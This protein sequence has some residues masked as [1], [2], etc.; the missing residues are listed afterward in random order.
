MGILIKNGEI[1]TASDRFKGDVYCSDGKIMAVGPNL[2]KGSSQ[3]EVIDA[4]GNVGS[5]A[6]QAHVPH[7][8]DLGP[9]AVDDGPAYS[10]VGCAPSAPEEVVGK[11][12]AEAA[13]VTVAK[14]AETP[15]EFGLGQNSKS[16]CACTIWSGA[17]V[18]SNTRI[19]D[20]NFR[21]KSVQ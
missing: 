12:L 18:N 11:D 2:E 16:S 3:D 4:S 10:V 13:E 20:W 15:D 7:D 17:A 8:I 19:I 14:V 21:L 5:A 6:W 1:V 9:Y